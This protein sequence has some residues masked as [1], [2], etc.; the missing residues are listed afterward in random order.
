MSNVL[1]VLDQSG[2]KTVCFGTDGKALN[3]EDT[4]LLNYRKKETW[5]LFLQEIIEF[6]DKFHIDG[7]HLDNGQAWP[8]IMVLDAEEMYR[9][10][11]DG[12]RAYTDEQIFNGD[13]VIQDE[14][15][16]YDHKF[17]IFFTFLLV[18]GAQPSAISTLIPSL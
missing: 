1:N 14:R 5:D 9:L 17:N 15:S 7:I 13:V 4:A 3:F 11:P 8:Q 6:T 10:D 2:K 18:S 12:T 16:G